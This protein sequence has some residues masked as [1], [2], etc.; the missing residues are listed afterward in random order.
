[1]RNKQFPIY[2][3]DTDYNTNA[4]SYYDDLARKQKLIQL[5]AEKIWEYDDEIKEYFKRWEDNLLNINDDVIKMMVTWLDDGTL[6][7]IINEEIF[8][9]KLD[10]DEFYDYQEVVNDLLDDLLNDLIQ[11]END[12]KQSEIT[13]NFKMFGLDG[14]PKYYNENTKKYYT[15]PTFTS[16][17]TNDDS[18]QI[19]EAFQFANEHN[20]KIVNLQGEYVI[21]DVRNIQVLQSVDFGDSVFHVDESTVTG[22]NYIFRIESKHEFK[23]VPTVIRNQM[24]NLKQKQTN[25]EALIDLEDSTMLI[26]DNTSIVGKREGDNGTPKRDLFYIG[27]GGE[28]DGE[29]AWDYTSLTSALYKKTDETYLTFEGGVF[30]YSGNLQGTSSGYQRTGIYIN[31]DRVIIR[32]QN[33]TYEVK[34]YSNVTGAR[35]FG[36]Y[37]LLECYDIVFENVHF[38]SRL[39]QDSNYGF[40]GRLVTSMKMINVKNISGGDYAPVFGTNEMKDIYIE[41]C[42]LSRLD[43]HFN[44][45]N[46]TLINSSLGTFNLTGGGVLYVDNVIVNHR[47]FL[48]LRSDYGGTWNGDIIIKNSKSI[49]GETGKPYVVFSYNDDG[50][51]YGQDIAYGKKIIVDNFTFEFNNTVNQNVPQIFYTSGHLSFGGKEPIYPHLIKLN[52]IVV[53]GVNR[54]VDLMEKYRIWSTRT[55]QTNSYQTV[56]GNSE[57]NKTNALFHFKNIKLEKYVER[58]LNNNVGKNI[59]LDNGSTSENNTNH[60]IVPEIIFENCSNI[61]ANLK[62]VAKVKIIGGSVNMIKANKETVIELINTDIKSDFL[63]NS[64]YKFAFEL[65][66]ALVKF[67]GVTIFNPRVNNV[68]SNN[69]YYLGLFGYSWN[70]DL[71]SGLIPKPSNHI[72][73]Q[74]SPSAFNALIE[75]TGSS[76]KA[77][78]VSSVLRMSD[79]GNYISS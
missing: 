21:R 55:D 19:N 75:L 62:L 42:V 40:T 68:T 46:V 69:L 9:M 20:L 50:I 15:D 70:D 47:L 65:N 28:I 2:P 56:N 16:E 72:G 63:K 7:D 8:N 66:N 29:L 23:E 12:F 54:G 49:V 57:I 45:W 27:Q 58:N 1:M 52:N 32:N 53:E 74:F 59:Y 4:P 37:E 24:K 71:V 38:K 64:N 31:R 3:D 18:V 51:D 35:M 5:L 30:K 10:S 36:F 34:D 26:E 17:Y 48:N 13:V 33:L 11:L 78:E 39:D 79:T 43:V 60:S 6:T 41:N 14:K 44:A 77:T 73:T 25:I 22:Y 61:S 67:N 76:S